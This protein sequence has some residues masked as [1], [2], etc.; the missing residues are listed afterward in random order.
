ME[1]THP[2]PI[3]N[4][5]LQTTDALLRRTPL[6]RRFCEKLCIV[7]SGDGHALRVDFHGPGDFEFHAEMRLPH[8]H[9][10]ADVPRSGMLEKLLH[11]AEESFVQFY[12]Q[13]LAKKEQAEAAPAAPAVP[14]AEA[15]PEADELWP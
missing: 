4:E 12:D 13:H 2:H 8:E 15:D 1:V 3:L 6:F 7:K 9:V 5:V 14:P 10:W 11:E